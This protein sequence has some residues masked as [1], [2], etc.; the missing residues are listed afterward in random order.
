M[1]NDAKKRTA[2]GYMD[3]PHVLAHEL[4]HTKVGGSAWVS[5]PMSADHGCML[6]GLAQQ[7][8]MLID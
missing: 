6:A 4:M 5:H 7:D 3:L 2:D 1:F 8:T